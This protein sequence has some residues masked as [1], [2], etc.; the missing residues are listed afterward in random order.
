MSNL[1][2]I[3]IGLR[4]QAIHSNNDENL[5]YIL[6]MPFNAAVVDVKSME[7]WYLAE[8]SKK[9][10]L[11]SKGLKVRSHKSK[12]YTEELQFLLRPDRMNSGML[13]SDDT[14]LANTVSDK[15]DLGL[16]TPDVSLVKQYSHEM[17]VFKQSGQLPSINQVMEGLFQHIV[18]NFDR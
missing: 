3:R 14:T 1:D 6:E 10:K 2:N 18:S 9:H 17:S 15:R 5:G 4:K 11:V 12:K 7:A 8:P 16:S 13:L